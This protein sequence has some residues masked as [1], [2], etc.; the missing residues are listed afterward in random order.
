MLPEVEAYYAAQD[1]DKFADEWDRVSRENPVPDWNH[2][3]SPEQ[4]TAYF[5]AEEK[6]NAAMRALDRAHK[7]KQASAYQGLVKSKDPMVRFLIT[8][9][10]I[11]S[12][13]P[14]HAE[15][16]LKA[17]P[18]TR[19]EVEEFGESKGWCGEYEQLLRRA[20]KA[21]VLPERAPDLADI[22]PLVREVAN[23]FSLRECRIRAI[24]R[25]HLPDLI[26]SAK[27]KEAQQAEQSPQVAT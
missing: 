7:E 27:A 11:Q 15:D 16:V 5:A 1:S 19:E 9:R 23:E 8:D 12:K 24:F 13:Y 3:M 2:T 20:E 14:L 22:E 26:A 4:V 18:M 21:G 10:L 25:K 6:R 17:L